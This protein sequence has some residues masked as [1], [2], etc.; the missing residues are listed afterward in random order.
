MFLY[1]TP[2]HSEA[3]MLTGRDLLRPS[4]NGIAGLRQPKAKRYRLSLRLLHILVM[5]V[6]QSG[7]TPD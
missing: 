5:K 2:F 4:V 1:D 3:R 7:L 6:M